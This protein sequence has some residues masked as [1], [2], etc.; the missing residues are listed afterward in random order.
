DEDDDDRWLPRSRDD[1]D[2]GDSDGET[3]HGASWATRV[4]RD[5]P[6]P[7][8]SPRPLSRSGSF[9][10]HGGATAVA[11]TLDD[12]DYDDED[13]IERTL[14][15]DGAPTSELA[16][17]FSYL[18]LGANELARFLLTIESIYSEVLASLRSLENDAAVAPEER[19][20][21]AQISLD[22]RAEVLFRGAVVRDRGREHDVL[23]IVRELLEGMPGDGQGNGGKPAAAMVAK[24]GDGPAVTLESPEEVA[25]A[26]SAD[27]SIEARVR[28]LLP[29]ASDTT[30]ASL[31]ELVRSLSD[32]VFRRRNLWGLRCR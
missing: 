9:P 30:V 1:D 15:V 11:A 31:G 28:Q 2:S 25:G 27:E 4:P 7:V 13:D 5:E 29:T 24:A 26:P 6:T 16:V 8:V 17:E 23:G 21:V 18:Y 14:V 22:S 10:V 19:L 20:R 3:T 12:Y 32:E